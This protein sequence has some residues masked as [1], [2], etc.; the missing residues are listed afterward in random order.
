MNK[1]SSSVRQ[2]SRCFKCISNAHIKTVLHCIRE[3]RCFLTARV[4]LWN[5]VLLHECL[6]WQTLAFIMK[7][8]T[9]MLCRVGSR[10]R[11]ATI[12]MP[13]VLHCDEILEAAKHF[14]VFAILH[15][16]EAHCSCRCHC[17]GD[18][19]NHDEYSSRPWNAWLIRKDCASSWPS[20]V[21]W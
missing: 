3:A 19:H 5:L 2:G 20:V 12:P 7:T 15:L 6:L 17:C 16:I 8:W 1:R 4:C 13:W 9:M 21:P 18:K 14:L 10:S 11:D